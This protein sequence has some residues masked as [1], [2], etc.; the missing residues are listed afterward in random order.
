MLRGVYVARAQALSLVDDG[1]LVADRVRTEADR[2]GQD[3][4]VGRGRLDRRAID[5]CRTRGAQVAS[6]AAQP[7]SLAAA[8][9]PLT[10]PSTA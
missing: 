5:K 6:R 7:P 8:R 1:R 3:V 10:L 2:L 9:E 4:G